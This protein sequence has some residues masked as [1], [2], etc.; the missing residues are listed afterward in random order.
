MNYDIVAIGSSDANTLEV[1]VLSSPSAVVGGASATPSGEAPVGT[2]GLTEP[3][4]PE[5][6]SSP[7][8]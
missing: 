4:T 7:T 6:V 2:P 5:V 1:I 8:E 3:A